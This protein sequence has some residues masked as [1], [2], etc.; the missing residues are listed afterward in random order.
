MKKFGL[1]LFVGVLCMFATAWAGDFFNKN[2]AAAIE[3]EQPVIPEAAPGQKLI[4][5]PGDSKNC[6]DEWYADVSIDSWTLSG[7]AKDPRIEPPTFGCTS[8][9]KEKATCLFNIQGHKNPNNPDIDKFVFLASVEKSINN[10]EATN[11][12]MT[13]AVPGGATFTMMEDEVGADGKTDNPI[14]IYE[15]KTYS[16]QTVNEPVQNNGKYQELSYQQCKATEEKPVNCR[17][18]ITKAIPMPDES[19]DMDY[20]KQR[21]FSVSGTYQCDSLSAIK[22]EPKEVMGVIGRHEVVVNKNLNGNFRNACMT[23]SINDAEKM[24]NQGKES[25]Q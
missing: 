12:N 18:N 1:I 20:A 9:D 10:L 7:N 19:V 5:L 15:S 4:P 2:K 21:M 3:S 24:M 16:C 25:K 14:R 13:E 17:L 11:Y 8:V 6:R 23:F 22:T